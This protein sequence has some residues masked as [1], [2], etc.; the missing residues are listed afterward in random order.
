M[1]DAIGLLECL[2]IQDSDT[3]VVKGTG[4]IQHYHL[5]TNM[6]VIYGLREAEI[7]T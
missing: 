4:L 3:A 6:V 5:M 1:T 7:G 2:S